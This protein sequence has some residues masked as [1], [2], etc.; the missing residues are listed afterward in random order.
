MGRFKKI[1]LVPKL[2]IAIIL[3]ILAGAYLP[4]GITRIAVHFYHLLFHL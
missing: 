3:G 1:G 2:I 4:V